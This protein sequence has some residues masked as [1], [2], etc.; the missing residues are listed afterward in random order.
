MKRYLI[1]LLLLVNGFS[2]S[3][4]I[5]YSNRLFTFGGTLAKLDQ[6]EK[7]D[8]R[9]RL[10][11]VTYLGSHNSYANVEEG[12]VY[13]Q[14][15]W[16][17]ENQ[18]KR[19]VRHFLLDI[20]PSQ[21]RL[22][23]CHNRCVISSV[24]KLG[25]RNRDLRSALVLVKSWLDEHPD[26]IVTLELENYATG[27]QTYEIIKSVSGL[28][29]Y[30]LK[31][32]DYE[33]QA[34]RGRWPT[35]QYLVNNN[36]RLIIFDTQ[37]NHHYAFDTYVYL[38]RNAY[39]ALDIEKAACLRGPEVP[40]QSLYQLN[41]FGTITSPS[42]CYN[43]PARLQQVLKRCQEK[44]VVPEGKSPNFIAID[45]VDRGNAM[46]WVNELNRQAARGIDA[47]LG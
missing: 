12:F 35:I 2:K 47:S 21:G 8:P 3:R 18:L 31:R 43:E 1:I 15:F 36:K 4:P 13:A 45:F 7:P 9:L 20:W 41:Y 6:W 5:S 14:Q 16:S 25:R 19:G 22:F 34:H 26:E 39:G 11:Q 28:E 30:I 27:D 33:P 24:L 37:D 17:L 29:A 46:R 40:S 38:L 42:P 32:A 23:L 10:D 44:G